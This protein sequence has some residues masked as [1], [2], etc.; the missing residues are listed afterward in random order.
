MH[1]S[2]C[3]GPETKQLQVYSRTV[4]SLSGV[5][6]SCSL[7]RGWHRV[8][9]PA[10]EALKHH[11]PH[12]LP[13]LCFLGV[14][15]VW[16]HSI[17]PPCVSCLLPYLPQQSWLNPFGTVNQNK[18]SAPL[19]ASVRVIYR[20]NWTR[21][22]DKKETAF[23]RVSAPVPTNLVPDRVSQS[24]SRLQKEYSIHIVHWLQ[25]AEILPHQALSCSLPILPSVLQV[26]GIKPG[27]IKWQTSKCNCDCNNYFPR[28]G[29]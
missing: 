11:Q 7:S 9:A 22:T 15:E 6:V 12:F 19:V 27:Q 1:L 20:S 26:L 24:I 29:N 28:Y 3:P 16:S 13:T 10:G 8:R 25:V 18:P 5:A 2:A 14:D 23:Y 17:W 21:N 4:T